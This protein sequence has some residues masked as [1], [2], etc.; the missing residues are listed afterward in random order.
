MIRALAGTGRL[1]GSTDVFLLEEQQT[2]DKMRGQV[3]K[4]RFFWAQSDVKPYGFRKPCICPRCHAVR[5]LSTREERDKAVEF[6]C[7]SNFPPYSE[8]TKK[9]FPVKKAKKGQQASS[10]CGYVKRIDIPPRRVGL[11][12][13]NGGFWCVEAKLKSY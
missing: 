8:Y 9:R 11:R 7:S 10:K 4:Y 6:I 2:Q 3:G 12:G 13:S 1:N 5:T